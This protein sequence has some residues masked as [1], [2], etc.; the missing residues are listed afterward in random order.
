MEVFSFVFSPMGVNTYV[1]AD[2]SGDCAVIDC[3]CFDD[4][5]FQ[6]LVALIDGK[7]LKP[8]LLLNTHCHPDHIFGNGRMLAK[9]NLKT[10]CHKG[11][12]FNLKNAVKYAAV[13]D[14][15]IDE[16]PSPGKFLEG[17]EVLTFG[18]SV[19]KVLF[20]PGHSAGGLAFYCEKEGLAFT[21]DALF[22][23]T[24]GRTDLHGGDYKQLL[25]SI[26]NELFSLP[27][28]TV[29]CPGH[30]GESTIGMEIES[31]PYFNQI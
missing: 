2:K 30:G 25:N 21:G 14:L 26:R 12:E 17:G 15:E 16:P 22:E 4:G 6:K 11:E 5:E 3:G 8:V 29:I 19:L 18:S 7:G 24:I 20:I 27:K 23:G 1:L 10:L 28:E 31:K 9:Y 13:F